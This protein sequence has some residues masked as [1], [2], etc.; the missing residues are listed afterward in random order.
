MSLIEAGRAAIG[1]VVTN[2]LRTF[3]TALGVV[4][5]VA[6]VIAL[7]SV[8]Y[9]A[10][11]AIAGQI[12]ALGTNLLT[13]TPADSRVALGLADAERLAT[14]VA[15]LTDVVPTV[16]SRGTVK[17]RLNSYDTTVM[18]VS[19]GYLALRGYALSGGRFL[20]SVDLDLNRK[21]AVVGHT[22]VGELFKG[23]EPVGQQ[24]MV[25]GQQFTVVGVLDEK[26]ASM[27]MSPDDVVLIPVTTAQRLN[28]SDRLTAIYAQ[29]S[30]PALAAPTV[31]QIQRIFELRFG[32]SGQVRVQSQDE[33][34]ETVETAS[35][36]TTMMLAAIAGISLLVGGIGIMNIMLVSVTERTREI[37]L[38][39]AVGAKPRD[40]TGQFLL[41]ALLISLGG[42]VIGVGVGIAAAEALGRYGSWTTSVSPDSVVMSFGFAAMIGV[43]F[44]LYP[45][46]KAAGMDPIAALRYE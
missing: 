44:G 40:I 32:R 8:G 27:G 18:G 14:R 4:I 10:S 28:S 5:G 21:V 13:I 43:G 26:G 24:V 36:T 31:A 30:D 2:K 34:L 12:A 7:V 38:R 45:A 39:K 19:S 22:V 46:L 20:T 29:L 6:A 41:E 25:L 11:Q 1:A 9:G 17:W 37:G 33:L 35:R 16:S 23:Q 3:L 42:G 15:S